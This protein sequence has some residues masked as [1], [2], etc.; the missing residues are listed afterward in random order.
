MQY[1][2]L[3][4]EN[5]PDIRLGEV[6]FASA[7]KKISAQISKLQKQGKI[8]KIAP[9]LYTSNLDDTAEEII[10]RNL[11]IIL[12]NLYP[13]AIISHRS[14]FEFKPTEASHIFLTYKYTRKINLPGITIRLLEGPKPIE[15]DNPFSGNLFTSQ[16]ARAFLENLQLSKR[17]GPTSKTLTI[18]EI[19]E[20]LEQIVRINGEDELNTLRDNARDVAKKLTMKKEFARLDTLISALLTT[21]DANVLSSPLAAARAFGFPYDP[22][23]TQ[24]FEELFRAL[25][26]KEFEYRPD[27]NTSTQSFRNFAFF[28]SYFSNYI[29]GTVFDV[30]EAKQIIETNQPLPSRNEDS[31]DVL[32]TYQIVS[33][34]QEMSK[35][36]TTTDELISILQYRHKI[37]LSARTDKNPGLFKDRNNFAGQ[38]SFVDFNLVKGTLIKSFD[39][40]QA[41]RHPFAKAA[42]MMFVISE[43]HPFLDGN[44]RMARVMMN[45]ELVSKGQSKIIIPTVFREDYL[46]VLRKLTRQQETAPYIR[47]LH[48]AFEF[49]SF[50]YSDNMDEMQH[51]LEDCDAFL[52]HTEGKLKI[53]KRE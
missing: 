11:F 30:E 25:L 10:R 48:R 13:G 41:L 49:S 39:F 35:T 44:G 15:G 18:P 46:G 21:R 4:M 53:I 19:E 37:L 40:Y 43:V 16:R 47:M 2:C 22:M 14:A 29:E 6:I 3:I 20:K 51:H 45:A 24:L 31:H 5:I 34:Q 12:G 32:G 26:T 33:N 27:K 36:P 7:D 50:V 17:P 42:Y 52:E 38:T 8:R 9:R 28:E 1:Y 23:R